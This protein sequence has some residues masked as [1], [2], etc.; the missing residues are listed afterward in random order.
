MEWGYEDCPYCEGK[1]KRWAVKAE[2]LRARR[3]G[4][5]L[6]LREVARRASLSPAYVSDVERGNRRVTEK[7]ARFYRDLKEEA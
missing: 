2:T 7:L 1:G 6:S 3:E 4:L 5:G